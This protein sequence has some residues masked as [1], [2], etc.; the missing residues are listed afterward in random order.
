M[1][2]EAF[3]TRNIN[4]LFP[5]FGGD[6]KAR[7]LAWLHIPSNTEFKKAA[8]AGFI[9]KSEFQHRVAFL[10]GKVSGLHRKLFKHLGRGWGTKPCCSE[11]EQKLSHYY[12]LFLKKINLP[13]VSHVLTCNIFL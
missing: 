1:N 2:T 7:I 6:K 4:L 12:N 3:S 5:F 13:H 11:H 8:V 9:W 10:W